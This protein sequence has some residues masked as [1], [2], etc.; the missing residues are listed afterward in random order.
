MSN[1]LKV[2][3]RVAAIAWLA[4]SGSARGD[5]GGAATEGGKATAHAALE[6]GADLP[7]APP[8]LPT[9]ASEQPRAGIDERTMGGKREATRKALARAAERAVDDGR[10]AHL[11]AA[12]RAALA[13]VAAAARST[14][15]DSRAAA[16]QAR[17]AIVKA[18]ARGH[19]STG[20][21]VEARP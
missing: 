13:S 6:E 19:G 11:E 20:S 16:G 18:S 10:S 14:S 7:A 8:W 5:E 3:A 9:Q 17:T 21:P 2:M 4:T 15:A 12:S 1:G